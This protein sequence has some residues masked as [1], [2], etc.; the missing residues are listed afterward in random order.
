M[1]NEELK[2]DTIFCLLSAGDA[3]L[4]YNNT[5]YSTPAPFNIHVI[6]DAVIYKISNYDLKN[7]REKEPIFDKLVQLN[8]HK[9]INQLVENSKIHTYIKA[10]TR[11]KKLLELRYNKRQRCCCDSCP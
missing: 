1:Y 10:L 3:I 5:P 2:K 6:K 7:L 11:Y 8:S 4:S 9:M